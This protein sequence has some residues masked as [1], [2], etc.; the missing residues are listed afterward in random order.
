MIKKLEKISFSL[1]LAVAMAATAVGFAA[2]GTVDYCKD[3]QARKSGNLATVEMA[4]TDFTVDGIREKDGAWQTTDGDPQ[5]L[6]PLNG[7]FTGIAIRADYLV[8]SGDV[9]VYY[10]TAPGTDFSRKNRVYLSQDKNDPQL[11]TGSIPL[12]N[13]A[14][15]RLD[16]TTVAGNMIDFQSII[17]N[18]SMSLADYLA[19]TPYKLLMWAICSLLLAAI[20]RFV[21]E[22]FTKKFE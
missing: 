9:I 14:D 4:V 15:L 8:Y 17:I 19:V 7:G 12:T 2:K 11:Y 22:F 10:T 3:V 21:Q 13:V 5:M 6:Y 18:P 1:I 20:L 16:P